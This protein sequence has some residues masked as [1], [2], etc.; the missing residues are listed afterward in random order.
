MLNILFLV[1]FNKDC[2]FLTM[3]NIC[4]LSSQANNTQTPNLTNLKKIQSSRIQGF[5]NKRS[6]ASGC[7]HKMI[8]NLS[9][10][11]VFL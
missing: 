4:L 2:M 8:R 9:L 3:V 1:N 7:N 11:Q 5:N 10:K 6:T